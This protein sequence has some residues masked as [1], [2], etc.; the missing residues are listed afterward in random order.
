MALTAPSTPKRRPMASSVCSLKTAVVGLH[1]RSMPRRGVLVS[2]IFV[3]FNGSEESEEAPRWALKEAKV[4]Q[5]TL[6]IVRAWRQ[7]NIY[8]R[9]PY[10]RTDP[11]ELHALAVRSLE[12]A[13]PKL[14]A[15][16]TLPPMERLAVE[17]DAAQALVKVAQDAE[18][19]VLGSRRNRKLKTLLFGSVSQQCARSANYTVVVVR[20]ADSKGPVD[21]AVVKGEGAGIVSDRLDALHERED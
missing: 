10:E 8:L 4:W 17:G 2:V 21:K 9:V 15:Q 3:G 6:R 16:N 1:E 5:A 12:A 13:L 19:L 18:M 11:G 14:G 20:Q 7:P